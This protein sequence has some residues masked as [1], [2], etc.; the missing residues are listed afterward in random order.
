MRI[1]I[2]HF[3]GG[4]IDPQAESRVRHACRHLENFIPQIYG[5]VERRPG[6]KF[7]YSSVLPYNHQAVF[8][9]DY[10]TLRATTALGNSP[11]PATG[12]MTA[13]PWTARSV[14]GTSSQQPNCAGFP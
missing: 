13:A 9:G 11:V 1:P 7:M 14:W 10:P 8:V 4:E 6:T 5:N 3:T 2:K 12:R